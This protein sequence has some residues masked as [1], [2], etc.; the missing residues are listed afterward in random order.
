[1]EF[2]DRLAE[3]VDAAKT[4]LDLEGLRKTRS[5]LASLEFS[6]LLM[7]LVARSHND[8]AER[9]RL[10]ALLEGL[11]F[12]FRD[13]TESRKELHQQMHALA[14]GGGSTLM[15][16]A[17]LAAATQVLAFLPF[18]LLPLGAGLY[19][20][21]RGSREAVRLALDISALNDIVGLLERHIEALRSG[22]IAR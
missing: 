6:S 16:G 12:S 8:L 5:L 18:A 17:V 22:D 3:L 20:A 15:V 14:I 21:W 9:Q 11:L 10:A 13:Q 19:A 4:K 2:Q 7:D 1:M